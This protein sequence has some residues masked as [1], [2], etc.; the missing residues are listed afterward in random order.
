[1]LM[2]PGDKWE[3]V[4][5]PSLAYGTKG[6]SPNIPGDA[7][8]IF[9]MQLLSVPQAPRVRHAW[10][11]RWLARVGLLQGFGMEPLGVNGPAQERCC[12]KSLTCSL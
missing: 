4:I 5:P 7:T 12:V 3:V 2:R 9:E 6:F 1:M 10:S 11:F 8:L